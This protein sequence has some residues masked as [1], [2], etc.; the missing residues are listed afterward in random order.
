M[1]QT[2]PVLVN[3]YTVYIVAFGMADLSGVTIEA[4]RIGICAHDISLEGSKLDA[5]GRG[6][7]S[8]EGIGAG[9]GRATCSGSGGAHGGQGG[10]GSAYEQENADDCAARA[11]EPYYFGR[12][13]RYEGSGGGSGV[14]KGHLGGSGGGIIWLTTPNT[15]KLSKGSVFRSR[16]SKTG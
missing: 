10:F 16:P 6:C 3:N 15:I 2:L 4:P 13:A 14:R 7:V 11:T 8:D 5:T 1:R 12:E 9:A